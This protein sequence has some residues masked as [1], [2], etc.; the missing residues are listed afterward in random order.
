MAKTSLTEGMREH[1]PVC[2]C[3]R[4]RAPEA[5]DILMHRLSP[6]P[7]PTHLIRPFQFHTDISQ[8][9]QMGNKERG[10]PF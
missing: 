5:A 3:A 4:V 10:K 2:V 6:R 7:L 9:P 1:L 8:S